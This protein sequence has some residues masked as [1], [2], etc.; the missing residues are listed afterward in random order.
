MAN[1]AKLLLGLDKF[2]LTAHHKDI[3]RTSEG[4]CDSDSTISMDDSELEEQHKRLTA[5]QSIPTQS[6]TIEIA[7]EPVQS[8]D[9]QITLP[10]LF[11]NPNLHLTTERP[12]VESFDTFASSQGFSQESVIS[13]ENFA[14]DP[15]YTPPESVERSQSSSSSSDDDAPVLPIPKKR[16]PSVRLFDS[17]DSD[18]QIT[19][20]I[21]ALNNTVKRKMSQSS[22][23]DFFIAK[24]EKMEPKRI[25]KITNYFDTNDQK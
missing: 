3:P 16:P 20:F 8:Y 23:M 17:D 9:S 12:A 6:E 2:G 1:Q 14:N 22:I 11:H 25:N 5:T 24:K 4:E 18:V 19:G 21:S 10:D 7:N 15:T 13:D